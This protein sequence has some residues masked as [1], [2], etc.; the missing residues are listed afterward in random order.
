MGF[1]AALLKV[2]EFEQAVANTPRPKITP[3]F[4]F[5]ISPS[6]SSHPNKISG[7]EIADS[8]HHDKVR[9]LFSDHDRSELTAAGMRADTTI[10]AQASASERAS[11]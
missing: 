5:F 10:C 1:V 8:R 9:G 3:N 11:W 2:L 4:R 6:K 7:L